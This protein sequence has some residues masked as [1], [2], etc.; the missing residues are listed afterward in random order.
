MSVALTGKRI[1]RLP[2]V[3]EIVGVSRSTISRWVEKREFPAPIKLGG[4][5]SRCVGWLSH[6]VYD[7]MDQRS[8][9][10]SLPAIAS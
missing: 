1:L 5:N 3:L 10:R 9:A 6:E 4:S 8:E 7:W 2:E